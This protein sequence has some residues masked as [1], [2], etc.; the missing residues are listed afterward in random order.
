MTKKLFAATGMMLA[1][2]LPLLGANDD[3]LAAARYFGGTWKCAGTTWT[4]AP[5]AQGSAWTRVNYGGPM[6]DGTAVLGYVAGLH[7]WLYRDFHANGA[8]ADLTS[9]GPIAGRWEWTGPYYPAE[10]GAAISSRVT[11]LQRSPTRYDRI[12]EILRKQEFTQ[13]G[14][15]SCVKVIR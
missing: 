8:Y 4:F 1:L 6:P 9:P 2:A 15:D 11:Y 14:T 5:L 7:S 3:P 10:G 13:M 12:F